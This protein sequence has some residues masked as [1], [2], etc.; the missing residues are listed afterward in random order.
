MDAFSVSNGGLGF[1]RGRTFV[2]VSWH[3]ETANNSAGFV[4]GNISSL[5]VVR[6]WQGCDAERHSGEGQGV[7]IQLHFCFVLFSVLGRKG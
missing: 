4:D 3:Y 2:V 1:V 7:Q 5:V 6:S